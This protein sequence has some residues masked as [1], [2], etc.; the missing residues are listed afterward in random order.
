MSSRVCLFCRGRLGA[1]RA[2]E[3]VVPRWLLEHLGIRKEDLFQAV[4]KS[5]DSSITETR[6][7]VGSQFVEGRICEECNSGWMSDLEGQAKDLITP[8]LDGTRAVFSLS[9]EERF[10]LARWAVKTAYVLSY[11]TPLRDPVPQAH[12]QQIHGDKAKVPEMVAIFMCQREKTREFAYY[13]RNKWEVGEAVPTPEP[14]ERYKIGLEF[15][16]LF[17]LVAYWPESTSRYLLGAGLHIPVYP[18]VI[19]PCR[20][21]AYDGSS[22]YDSASYLG[23]FVDSLGILR[24]RQGIG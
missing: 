15:R 24:A 20:F 6:V 21:I 19:Y 22:V 11:A 10:L 12:L 5:V 1:N 7:T 3:H 17:L 16:R 9:V 2:K 4:A 14:D 18:Q 8:L 23:L 13:Q